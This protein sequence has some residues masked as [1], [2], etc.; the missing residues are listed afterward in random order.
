MLRKLLA[1]STIEMQ[2]FSEGRQ[3]GYKF[4][5]GLSP[6]RTGAS[7][8]VTGRPAGRRTQ[9]V[10]GARKPTN[11]T[12]VNAKSTGVE[13]ARPDSPSKDAASTRQVT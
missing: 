5:G 11:A 6:R 1:G 2:G 13:A 4:R 8:V 7:G 10:S 12:G 9:D 3:R